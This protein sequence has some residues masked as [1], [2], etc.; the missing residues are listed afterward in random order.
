[1]PD[2]SIFTHESG[3]QWDILSARLRELAFLNR[4][5]SITLK[6]DLNNRQEVFKYDGGIKEFILHL[7]K[8][9]SSMHPEVIHFEREKMMVLRLQCS[10]PM[11]LMKQFFIC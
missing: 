6:E 10:I 9:K 5:V 11:L 3:F 4:G 8:N 7:N 1:M 2:H